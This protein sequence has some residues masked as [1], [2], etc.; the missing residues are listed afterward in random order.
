MG[1][2]TRQKL[3]SEKTRVYA[4]KPR[5]KMPFKNSI[6][7]H[8]IPTEKDMYRRKKKRVLMLDN[9]RSFHGCI[10]AKCITVTAELNKKHCKLRGTRG[11][12]GKHAGK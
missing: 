2:E 5:L 4:Q 10:F 3:E 1:V 11:G 9:K 12:K 6:S 8:K 7:G